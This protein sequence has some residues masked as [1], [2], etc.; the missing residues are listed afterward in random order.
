MK[1]EQARAKGNLIFREWM[2]MGNPEAYNKLNES[3]REIIKSYMA[4]N[5]HAMGYKFHKGIVKLQTEELFNF[6]CDYVF[7]GTNENIEKVNA[8]EGGSVE[9]LMLVLDK[10]D[11]ICL[12]WS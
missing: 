11:G 5:S 8:A 2:L 3:N 10:S 1:L 6:C 12:I 7:N 4:E 9:Y